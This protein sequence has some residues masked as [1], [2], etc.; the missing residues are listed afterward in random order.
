MAETETAPD[1]GKITVERDA[2]TVTI[3]LPKKVRDLKDLDLKMIQE[4]ITSAVG[5]HALVM[6]QSTI[7]AVC[8]GHY[9]QIKFLFELAGLGPKK[10]A[11]APP[12]DDSLAQTL[13]QHLQALQPAAHAQEGDSPTTEAPERDIR[14]VK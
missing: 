1:D 5:D 3:K 10:S 6:V 11:D 7:E 14:T 8:A 2:K 12:Q 4:Q 13:L 9:S